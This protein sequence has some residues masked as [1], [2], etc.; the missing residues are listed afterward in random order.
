MNFLTNF[1]FLIL[2][3]GFASAQTDSSKTSPLKFMSYA[4]YHQYSTGN[5]KGMGLIAEVN[6][7][8]S[9]KNVMALAKELGLS[10]NQKSQVK[11]LL[12]E[13]N[14]KALEMGKFLIAEET[15][16]NKQFAGNTINEGSLVFYTN[17]IGALQGEL[18]NAYLKAHFRTFKILTAPQL[19]KYS[20]LSNKNK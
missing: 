13:M 18:R 17:K 15:K 3:S 11:I 4:D 9:P 1:I 10:E 6:N 2:L 5:D 19:K 16:L 14:R 20:Q 8:P 12:T 7:Y